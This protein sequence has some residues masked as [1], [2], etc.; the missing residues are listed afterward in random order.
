MVKGAGGGSVRGYVLLAGNV[1]RDRF[2]GFWAALLFTRVVGFVDQLL[3][4]FGSCRDVRGINGIV[5]LLRVGF[6]LGI[7]FDQGKGVLLSE[8]ATGK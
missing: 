5:L 7:W 6:P 4:M 1:V 8:R 3:E 2:L